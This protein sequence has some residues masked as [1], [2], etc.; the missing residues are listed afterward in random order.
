MSQK[1][2][3]KNILKKFKMENYVK[4]N[5]L[6]K[7]RVNMSNNDEGEKINPTIFKSLVESLRYLTCICSDILFG[8]GL[9]SIFIEIPTMTHLKAL[10]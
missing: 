9:V 7:C 8:Q 1:K 4:I 3:A 10:K 2:F 6:I 5:T